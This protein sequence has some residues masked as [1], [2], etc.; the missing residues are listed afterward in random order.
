MKTRA[1]AGKHVNAA[2]R[3]AGIM[4]AAFKRIPKEEQ[5]AVLRTVLNIKISRNK[6][7]PKRSSTLENLR[8]SSK[9]VTV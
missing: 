6:S 3:A 9:S 5:K 2:D 8:Q 4:L 7:I 1:K